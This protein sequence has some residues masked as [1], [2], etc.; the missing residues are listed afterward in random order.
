MPTVRPN[1]FYGEHVPPRIIGTEFEAS[2]QKIN[3]KGPDFSISIDGSLQ[4]QLSDEAH[5]ISAPGYHGLTL[6]N[7]ANIHNDVGHIEYAGPEAL[8]PRQ[9]AAADLAGNV[10]LAKVAQTISPNCGLYLR[11]GTE[12][13]IKKDDRVRDYTSGFHENYLVPADLLGS[14]T[15]RSVLPS[16][17]ATRVWAGAGMVGR[18]GFHMFQKAPGIG[19]IYS[20]G[21]SSRT[22]PHKKPMFLLRS[23]ALNQDGDINPDPKWGRVEVRFADP[24]QSTAG[25]FLAKA[26]ASLVLR[27][28]EHEQIT[29]ESLNKLKIIDPVVAKGN[30][31]TDLRFSQTY[32]TADGQRY[33]A[34]DIQEAFAETALDLSEE[35]EL[36]EDEVEAAHLWR[37]IIDD[38]RNCDVETHDF[39][40]VSDVVPFA[41]KLETLIRHYDYE[42]IHNKNADAVRRDL[43]WDR[44]EPIGTGQKYWAKVGG[45][46]AVIPEHLIK[47]LTVSAPRG[48]RAAVRGDLVLAGEAANASW[49]QVSRKNGKIV[50]IED[51]YRSY[52]AK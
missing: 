10:V 27:M 36:P 15:L 8:G 5:I 2:T 28:L 30:T 45:R 16:Y 4:S 14:I 6:Q 49:V 42:D 19:T 1:Q 29:G 23:A 38:L 18:D 26:S 40:P 7:G 25:T 37:E 21:L 48:T 50:D 35:I 20:T 24:S 47:E 32:K 3:P 12:I 43:I 52:L 13:D 51:P 46:Q 34:L 39:R 11:S 44:L 33:T 22:E 17:L 41:P 31:D 9:A